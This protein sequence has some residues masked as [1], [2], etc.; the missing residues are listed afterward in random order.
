MDKKIAFLKDVVETKKMLNANYKA[1][2]YKDIRDEEI[3][4]KEYSPIGK[5]VEKQTEAIIKSLQDTKLLALPSTE[6][7]NVIPSST[8]SIMSISSPIQTKL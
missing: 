4:E 6:I 1:A 7:A 2:K 8:P 5:H 3:R